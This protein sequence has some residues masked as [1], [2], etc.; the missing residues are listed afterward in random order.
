MDFQS[1]HTDPSSKMRKTKSENLLV[2]TTCV[3]ADALF[4]TKLDLG[5]AR[6]KRDI[7]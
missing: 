4:I 7:G 1:V 3:P 5:K 2:L 6:Q